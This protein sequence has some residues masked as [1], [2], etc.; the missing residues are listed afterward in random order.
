MY[1]YNMTLEDTAERKRERVKEKKKGS[2]E[3]G[4][5]TPKLSLYWSVLALMFHKITIT[6]Q[7]GTLGKSGQS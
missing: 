4:L 7:K 1:I 5:E 6:K 3:R 2:R